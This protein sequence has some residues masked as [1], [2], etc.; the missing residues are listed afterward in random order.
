MG[1]SF[2]DWFCRRLLHPFFRLLK[3]PGRKSEGVWNEKSTVFNKLNLNSQ[4]FFGRLW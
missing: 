2:L 1:F 3:A 4:H